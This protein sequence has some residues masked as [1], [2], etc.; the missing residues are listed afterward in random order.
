MPLT[1]DSYAHE[2]INDDTRLQLHFSLIK[3]GHYFYSPPHWHGHLEIVYIQKGEM[4]ARVNEQQYRLSDNDL[5]IVNSRELHS[6]KSS[7]NIEYLLLQIPCD[8][9]GRVITDV[10]L[11][12]F[13]EY[14]PA[15][16]REPAG[17]A[18]CG[19]LSELAKGHIRKRKTGICFIFPRWPMNFFISCTEIIPGKSH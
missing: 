7:E 14:F 8:Y 6:T 16:S 10:S 2:I 17:E 9:L 5:L 1:K 4:T 19:C 12:H 13:Q 3:D 18:L 11:I 15:S